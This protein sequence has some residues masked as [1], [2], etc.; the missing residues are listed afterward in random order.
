MGLA[1]E[2]FGTERLHQ[3]WCKRTDEQCRADE[4]EWARI[5]HGFG[6]DNVHSTLACPVC[7]AAAER[8]EEAK[9]F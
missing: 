4:A 7:E 5:D 3:P 9:V 2:N 1:C 8:A 6:S